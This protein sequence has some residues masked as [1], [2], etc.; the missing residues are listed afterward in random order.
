MRRPLCLDL[1]G[2][3]FDLTIVSPVDASTLP[4]CAA[5]CQPMSQIKP[6]LYVGS[7]RDLEINHLQNA[8]ITHVLNVAREVDPAAHE[9]HLAGFQVLHIP[10]ADEHRENI[11]DHIENACSFIEKAKVQHGKCLVHC[12]RGISRSPAIVVGYLMRQCGYEYDEAVAY[13]QSKRECVSLNIAFREFLMAYETPHMKSSRA[14]SHAFEE[15]A[16]DGSE[17]RGF[18]D[19]HDA[20][21]HDDATSEHAAQPTPGCSDGGEAGDST[22]SHAMLPRVDSTRSPS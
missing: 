4:V 22:L 7:W 17:G 14:S 3:A 11:I 5:T 20:E 1:T 15:E 16:R 8:G 18:E 12:R 9:K 10:L 6:H 2:P 21:V 13:V 19:G